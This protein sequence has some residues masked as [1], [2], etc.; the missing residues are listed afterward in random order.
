MGDEKDWKI[1]SFK[2]YMY[3]SKTRLNKNKTI[4]FHFSIIS[5]FFK[6]FF[7][8]KSFFF[9]ELKNEAFVNNLFPFY[10]NHEWDYSV[11]KKY[12]S[13]QKQN[14]WN[15]IKKRKTRQVDYPIFFIPRLSFLLTLNIFSLKLLMIC[16]LQ[17]AVHWIR[18]WNIFPAIIF[19]AADCSQSRLFQ[20]HTLIQ[21]YRY[22]WAMLVHALK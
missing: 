10:E 4:F 7:K 18:R 8:K 22:P 17:K 3:N 15:N 9:M 5:S 2:I 1:H 16:E 14:P 6:I 20:Q 12:K 11:L 19:S 13:R 21:R